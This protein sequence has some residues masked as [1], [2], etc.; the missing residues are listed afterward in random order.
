MC[1]LLDGSI[2]SEKHLDMKTPGMYTAPD[3]IC[4]HE[5]LVAIVSTQLPHF[6]PAEEMPRGCR[7][8]TI[9]DWKAN[10]LVAVSLASVIVTST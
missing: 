2:M 4:I 8:I 6:N 7:R 3:A 10:I 5:D 1:S 9:I